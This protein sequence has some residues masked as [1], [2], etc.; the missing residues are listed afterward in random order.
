MVISIELNRG[1]LANLQSIYE[2]VSEDSCLVNL[3]FMKFDVSHE[4]RTIMQSLDSMV[5]FEYPGGQ[6]SFHKDLKKYYEIQKHFN[7]ENAIIF[8]C[9]TNDMPPEQKLNRI[10]E[11]LVDFAEKAIIAP[12]SEHGF[13]DL[14]TEDILKSNV[15][16]VGMANATSDYYTYMAG[17]EAVE[18]AIANAKKIQARNTANQSIV[19]T[20][21]SLY[22]NDLIAH[23]IYAAQS[24]RELR[25]Q[26]S[27]ADS[28]Y[29]S[30]AISIDCSTDL[31]IR[32]KREKYLKEKYIPQMQRCA[33]NVIDEM[34]SLYCKH[35]ADVGKFSISCLDGIDEARST[36]LL[37][38]LGIVASKEGVIY[39]AIQLCPYNLKI[40]KE[41]YKNS[42][43]FQN[44]EKE[45]LSFFDCVNVLCGW[46]AK[47]ATHAQRGIVNNVKNSSEGIHAISFLT[48]KMDTEVCKQIFEEDLYKDINIYYRIGEAKQK[49]KSFTGI[50]AE[51]FPQLNSVSVSDF[52]EILKKCLKEEHLSNEDIDTYRQIGLNVFQI[53]SSLY[54][55]QIDC[56]EHVDKIILE[57]WDAEVG[58]ALLT[59]EI[60]KK[61]KNKEKDILRLQSELQKKKSSISNNSNGKGSTPGKYLLYGILGLSAFLIIGFL[62]VILEGETFPFLLFAGCGIL[63]FAFAALCAYSQNRTMNEIITYESDIARKRNE[64]RELRSELGRTKI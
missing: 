9:I 38:N 26:A 35:L 42:I 22:S 46:I 64:L 34:I 52:G 2:E 60:Q 51:L 61:I 33:Q 37:N 16:Y 47:Q 55:A 6:I 21:Y 45:I 39:K 27:R 62:L 28:E 57:M 20:G 43:P 41:Q 14:T 23:A 25:K 8:E 44:V 30:A 1:G 50:R 12:L 29:L 7:E 36:S 10:T 19:G 49:G 31:A 24:D 13:Y 54:N 18:K 40:Y 48:D 59:E 58:N 63:F 4:G 56:F 3:Y 11:F 15:G 5:V 17:E 53:L 32:E